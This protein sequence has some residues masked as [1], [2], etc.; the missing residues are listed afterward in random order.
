MSETAPYLVSGLIVRRGARCR[1]LLISALVE[2]HR[3]NLRKTGRL[4]SGD[5]GCTASDTRHYRPF[6]PL[7]V[8]LQA[9]RLPMTK[10]RIREITANTNSR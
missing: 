7:R 10:C 2:E 6:Y 8:L 4:D 1:V 3:M 9:V 5:S